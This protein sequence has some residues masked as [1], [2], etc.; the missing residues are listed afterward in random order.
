MPLSDAMLDFKFTRIMVIIM[1]KNASVHIIAPLLTPD[2]MIT[3]L[4]TTDRT[5]G[6]T[7]Y[8]PKIA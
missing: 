5:S 7:V 1:H 2:A 8:I 6:L 4:W 3:G